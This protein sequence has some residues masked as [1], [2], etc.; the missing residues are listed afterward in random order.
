MRVEHEISVSANTIAGFLFVGV[1]N[2]IEALCIER[3]NDLSVALL[4]R[5]MWFEFGVVGER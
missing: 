4:P 5:R 1:E 3:G 2:T